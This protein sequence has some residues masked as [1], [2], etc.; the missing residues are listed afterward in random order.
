[1][2]AAFLPERFPQHFSRR[3]SRLVNHAL[4]TEVDLADPELDPLEAMA[5]NVQVPTALCTDG[6]T[7]TRPHLHIQLCLRSA[8]PC[9]TERC[10]AT[11]LNTNLWHE[12]QICP[13]LQEDLCLCAE[14]AQGVLRFVSGAVL[15]P[16][17]WSLLEKLGENARC[18]SISCSRKACCMQGNSLRA[19]LLSFCKLVLQLAGS[20][21][22]HWAC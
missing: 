18:S 17:R 8:L 4:G 19:R 1:M 22:C 9:Q 13:L 16:H 6:A 10:S 15:F 20:C 14:D 21:T 7:E 11:G 12:T 3:G 5:V 2:L